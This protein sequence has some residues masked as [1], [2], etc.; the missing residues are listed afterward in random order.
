MGNWVV[1]SVCKVRKQKT[2]P[3]LNREKTGS[4]PGELR[5]REERNDAFMSEEMKN[6]M[7]EAAQQAEKSE[8]GKNRTVE[9]KLLWQLHKSGSFLRY[10]TEGRG[11]QRR[12][13]AAI[14]HQDSVSQ[15]QLM[16]LLEV[17]A[18]SL[19]EILGKLES[20]G[21]ILRKQNQEDKR[22]YDLS[23]TPAGLQALEELKAQYRES[24]Q[25]LFASLEEEEKEQL[26]AL[27]KKVLLDWKEKET[28][29]R[30]S[31]G[32][33]SEND[34]ARKDHH[35]GG[36]RHGYGEHHRGEHGRS[37]KGKSSQR[38]E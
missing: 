9:E 6:T 33:D 14:A 13:L 1:Y 22:T 26:S 23:I 4:R 27:L 24:A 31:H 21:L 10:Q 28:K 20:R 5:R 29:G 36:H 34:E 19:S 18:G 11:G 2:A 37:R 16:S 30:P 8:R 12:V 17:K 15:R 7:N 25:G 38:E 32:E 35:G 3:E